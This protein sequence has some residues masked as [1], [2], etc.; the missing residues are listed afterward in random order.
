[1]AKHS[2]QLEREPIWAGWCPIHG[3]APPAFDAGGYVCASC[4]KTVCAACI[5][6]TNIGVLCQNC[7]N[8]DRK[9]ITRLTPLYAQKQMSDPHRVWVARAAL[10][11]LA[12]TIPVALFS[13]LFAAPGYDATF[14]YAAQAA[15]FNAPLTAQGDIPSPS[16]D[17]SQQPAL[18]LLLSL[19]IVCLMGAYL[20]AMLK[21]YRDK[22]RH[23]HK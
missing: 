15:Q 11:I 6:S 23:A 16:F 7:L 14:R 10:L 4:R 8:R 22:N 13:V 2:F 9:K 21:N 12:V 3:G 17:L 5:Y 19:A 1:M 20:Y 18:A